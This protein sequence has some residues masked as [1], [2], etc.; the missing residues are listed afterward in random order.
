MADEVIVPTADVLPPGGNPAAQPPAPAVPPVAP[1]APPV[2]DALLDDNV[3]PP[4]PPVADAEPEPAAFPETGNAA[5]DLSLQFFGK[6]GI[7]ADSPEIVEAEK[8]NFQYLEAKLRSLGDK[9]K[10]W[11]SYL[12]IAREAHATITQNRTA[13]IAARR[14]VVHKAVGGEEEWKAI[15]QFVQ[16][17]AD[18]AEMKEVRS[19]LALGGQVAKAMAL[20]LQSQYN[21]N[22]P[23]DPKSPTVN[24]GARPNNGGPLTLTGYRDELSSLTEKIGA[25]RVNDSA[26]Y[27]ALRR[28]YAGVSA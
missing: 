15:V 16:A 1:V 12:A 13:A 20:M 4:V 28:K 10:G 27:A 23:R 14:E 9:A 3:Q 19:A 21:A 7:T 18:P 11:E 26:E 5:L 8:G 6:A 22:A 25:H 2:G 24:Q 17:N